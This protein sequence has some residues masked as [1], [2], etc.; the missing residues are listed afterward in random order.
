MVMPLEFALERGGG[1]WISGVPIEINHLFSEY[2]WSHLEV[3]TGRDE[4]HCEQ[5]RKYLK[6]Q[7][8]E[9]WLRKY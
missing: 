7:S 5:Y 6:I 1:G 3:A 2:F 8:H 9:H 4:I